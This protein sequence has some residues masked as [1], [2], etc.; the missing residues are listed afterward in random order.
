MPSNIPKISFL[1]HCS[2]EVWGGVQT[3]PYKLAHLFPGPEIPD[4]T[5][6]W[7]SHSCF[8][9]MVP[10]VGS[11]AR[12][13]RGETIQEKR[14]PRDTKVGTWELSLCSWPGLHLTPHNLTATFGSFLSPSHRVRNQPREQ[15]QHFPSPLWGGLPPGG[16][17]QRSRNRRGKERH[18]AATLG[19]CCDL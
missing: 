8:L 5:P 7:L 9:Y 10:S 19:S 3:P 4:S 2:P 17:E 6:S 1:M 13:H 11:L 14:F 18:W 16:R 12:S 15:I